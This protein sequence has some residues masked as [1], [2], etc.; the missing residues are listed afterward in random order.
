MIRFFFF[1]SDPG[2]EDGVDNGTASC[3]GAG[4]GLERG[5]GAAAW[6]IAGIEAGSDSPSSPASKETTEQY[7]SSEEMH[8]TRPSADHFMSDMGA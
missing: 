4:A 5:S 6:T 8:K 7:P 2:G 1:E 3:C